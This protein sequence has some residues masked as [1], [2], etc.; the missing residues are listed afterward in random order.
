MRYFPLNWNE[1]NGDKSFENLSVAT[2]LIP[3]ILFNPKVH[4]PSSYQPIT[5]PYSE[6]D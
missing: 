5:G 2:Q 4:L 1:F 6:P 3:R